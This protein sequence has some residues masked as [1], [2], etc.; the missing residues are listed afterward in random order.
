MNRAMGNLTVRNS[1]SLVALTMALAMVGCLDDGQGST[2]DISQP[3]GTPTIST[4]MT[5]YSATQSITV[6]WT[7][8]PGNEFDFVALMPAG[9]PAHSP[10]VEWQYTF[11][12]VSGN[13]TF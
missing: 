4:D 10:P 2:N 9:A 11:G 13:R 3:V 12:V 8:S 7:N 1:L 5:T 6:T